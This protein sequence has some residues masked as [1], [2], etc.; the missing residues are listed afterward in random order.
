MYVSIQAR[1]GRRIYEP[2]LLGWALIER[3][4]MEENLV[5]SKKQKYPMVYESFSNDYFVAARLLERHH[6]S[7]GYS[8]HYHYWRNFLEYDSYCDFHRMEHC[9]HSHLEERK[10]FPQHVA[11]MPSFRKAGRQSPDQLEE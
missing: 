7:V 10:A 3:T 4:L 1:R 9:S 2:K 6:V 5:A 8:S 11:L